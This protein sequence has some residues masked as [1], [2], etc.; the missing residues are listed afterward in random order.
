MPLGEQ[1]RQFVRGGPERNDEGQVEEQLERGGGAVV[2]GRVAAAHPDPAMAAV[3]DH[4][5]SLGRTPG[6]RPAPRQRIDGGRSASGTTAVSP[7]AVFADGTPLN[8][9]GTAPM[10]GWMM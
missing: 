7:A 1:V 2:L 3:L 4:C 5:G 8:V 6:R 10:P 9:Y